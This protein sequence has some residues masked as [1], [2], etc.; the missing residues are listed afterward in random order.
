MTGQAVHRSLDLGNVG[1]IHDVRNRVSIHRMPQVV[2]QRQYRNLGEIVFRQPDPAAKDRNQVVA[3]E[4]LRLRVRSVT[5]QAQLVRVCRPQQ[6]FVVASMR[7]VADGAALHEY[8][9][10]VNRL[11]FQV[12]D[13]TVA[14]QADVHGVRLWQPR[15]G[16]GVRVVAIGAIARGSGMLHLGFLD[17]LGFVGV[18]GDAKV[19]H[20]FLRQDDFSIFRR[21]VAH[22][23]TLLGKWRMEKLGHQLRLRRLVR[24]VALQAVRGTE[25][26][27]LVSLLQ[28][29][30]LRIVAVDAQRGSG[31]RQVKAIFNGRLGARLV[32]DVARLTTHVQRGVPA[33]FFRNI[34]PLRVAGEAEIVFFLA[35]GGLQQ[36]ELIV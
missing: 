20:V 1:R 24:V 6:M 16:A 32:G 8:R 11:L 22:L 30:V 19:L 12:G 34:Q 35:G 36:L 17:L 25:R 13:V 31:F 15:I 26:L 33:A 18:T 23:A 2:L 4:L 9:L 5:L 28:A 27:V 7:L 10:V 14:T 29:R 21:G 3:F